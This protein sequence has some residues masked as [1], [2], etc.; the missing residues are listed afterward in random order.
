MSEKEPITAY[1]GTTDTRY[2]SWEDLVAAEANGYV[3]VGV[4]TGPK[5]TVP[6]VVGPMTHEEAMR[7]RPTLRSKWK[8]EM[9]EGWSLK[10]FIRPAWKDLRRKGKG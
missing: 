2:D 7:R 6:V 10:V 9:G 1:S 4:A 5:Y 8:R 3:V